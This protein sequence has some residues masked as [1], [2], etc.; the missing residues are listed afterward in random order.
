MNLRNETT[1]FKTWYFETNCIY[2]FIA[3]RIK[4]SL[5]GLNYKIARCNCITQQT[6]HE[7]G[8]RPCFPKPQHLLSLPGIL[9]WFV[10]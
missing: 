9:F 6:Q 8:G 1:K 10:I 5:E 7:V 4:K 3:I 2:Y